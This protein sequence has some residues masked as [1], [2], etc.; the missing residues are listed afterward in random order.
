MHVCEGSTCLAPARQLWFLLNGTRTMPSTRKG[1][2]PFEP[3]W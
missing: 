3:S 2:S 1:E